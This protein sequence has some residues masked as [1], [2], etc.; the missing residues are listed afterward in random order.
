MWYVYI[1]RCADETLYTG[2]TTDPVRRLA[3]HQAGTGAKYTRAHKPLGFAYLE[4]Q[5][6]RSE[7]QSREWSIKQLSHDEKEMLIQSQDNDRTLFRELKLA[8]FFRG[9]GKQE[10]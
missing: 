7:A 1:L 4:Q 6:N 2:V 8:L 3:E 5:E 9:D 10:T